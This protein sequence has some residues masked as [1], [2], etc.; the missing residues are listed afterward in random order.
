MKKISG[1]LLCLALSILCTARVA[2]QES[3]PHAQK[4][5]VKWAHQQNSKLSQK[6]LRFFAEMASD[7]KPDAP[8]ALTRQDLPVAEGA[9]YGI[10]ASTTYNGIEKGPVALSKLTRVEADGKTFFIADYDS[11]IP[12]SC[13]SNIFLLKGTR[14]QSI[15]DSQGLRRAC[16]IFRLSPEGPVLFQTGGS[17][18]L[19]GWGEQ[20]NT[21]TEDGKLNEVLNV[22]VQNPN[23]YIR[24]KDLEENG[25]LAVVSRSRLFPPEELMEKLNKTDD[26]DD[27]NPFMYEITLWQWDGEK[28][29][30]GTRFFQVEGEKVDQK[31]VQ[32][33]QDQV[34]RAVLSNPEVEKY[35]HKTLDG[36]KQAALFFE[37]AE[38]SMTPA[39]K[40]QTEVNVG[41]KGEEGSPDSLST[42]RRFVFDTNQG[43]LL[44]SDAVVRSDEKPAQTEG[45]YNK[46]VFAEIQ[47]D[48]FFHRYNV[49]PLTDGLLYKQTGKGLQSSFD[50][51]DV[52][53]EAE[54]AH[55]DRYKFNTQTITGL[56][57]SPGQKAPSARQMAWA[58]AETG[59]EHWIR[60]VF[61]NPQTFQKVKVYWALDKG[62]FFKATKVRLI[63]KDEAGQEH[64]M[65]GPRDDSDPGMTS[66]VFEPQTA[67]ELILKQDEGGG[68]SGRPNLMWVGQLWAY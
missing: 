45:E 10:P 47:A 48:S 61:P 3:W 36:G 37:P 13:S 59:K 7:F 40:G 2:A 29:G 42:T 5:A 39:K 64:E 11:D 22:A 32:E 44:V 52:V 62:E 14:A 27:V 46:L 54:K 19:W 38:M 51:W 6:D 21:L 12:F 17:D 16:D 65:T 50:R 33:S 28:F 15:G 43:K 24:F 41:I 60:A 30:K 31:V 8:Y 26:Y 58:S 56:I 63:L 66:W 34:Y 53:V 55:G 1:L 20:L 4:V 49:M 57:L 23:S 25:H 18:G 9:K 35:I 67:S 68:F